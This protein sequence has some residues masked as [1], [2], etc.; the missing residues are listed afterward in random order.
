M[1]TWRVRMWTKII[2]ICTTYS[3]NGTQ[4]LASY[5]TI[6]KTCANK[7]LNV[8]ILNIDSGS[9][10]EHLSQYPSKYAWAQCGIDRINFPVA[11]TSRVSVIYC[12]LAGSVPQS[13]DLLRTS[14]RWD[15][16]IK[17]RDWLPRLLQCSVL[18][19]GQGQ[20][21]PAVKDAQMPHHTH[22]SSLL[23]EKP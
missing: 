20:S 17:C 4:P 7:E 6:I 5:L 22:C 1:C 8:N 3:S 15:S 14:P 10:L 2:V 21:Q 18:L 13:L 11:C 19:C 16:F 12:L 23:R 9:K